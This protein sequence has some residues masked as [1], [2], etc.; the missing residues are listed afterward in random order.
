MCPRMA[1]I[2]VTFQRTFSAIPRKEFLWREKICQTDRDV[3]NQFKPYWP[4]HI[5]AACVIHGCRPPYSAEHLGVKALTSQGRP[6]T[7]ME[8]TLYPRNKT[9]YVDESLWMPNGAVRE[10]DLWG[11]HRK[12]WMLLR[13]GLY[14][15]S[16]DIRG[17]RSVM[18]TPLSMRGRGCL[19]CQCSSCDPWY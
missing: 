15:G 6:R 8:V 16:A 18:Q 1:N 19:N 3:L 13:G 2:C 14:Y 11:A 17:S 7:N 4:F 9:L 12:Y 10:R 5:K